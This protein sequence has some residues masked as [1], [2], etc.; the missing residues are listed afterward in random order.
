VDGFPDVLADGFPGV[1]AEAFG[2]MEANPGN[3]D[4]SAGTPDASGVAVS[5]GPAAADAIGPGAPCGFL[6]ATGN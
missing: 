1:V 2:G 4:P 5:P 3:V 6:D